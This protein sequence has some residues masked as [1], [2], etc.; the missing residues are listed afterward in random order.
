MKIWTGKR[1]MPSPAIQGF[2]YT[3]YPMVP[4]SMAP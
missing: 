4:I 2:V 1:T 3:M